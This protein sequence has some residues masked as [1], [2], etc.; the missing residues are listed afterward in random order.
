MNYTL[1]QLRI[2]ST[3][4]SLG[5]VTKTAEALNISQP[6][7]SIQLRNFQANFDINLLESSGRRV[8]L[9]EFGKQIAK[10][11]TDILGQVSAIDYTVMSHK[12][13]LAGQLRVAIVST[14]KYVMPYFLSPFIREHTGI[15]IKMDVTNK[16][17]VL[18]SL[19]EGL[20]DFGLVSVVP[21]GYD[22]EYIELMDNELYLIGNSEMEV[23]YMLSASDFFQRFPLLLRE[24]GS[25]TR[26]ASEQFMKESNLINA[27]KIEIVSNEAIKQAII[28]GIGCSVMP[29][30]GIRQELERGTL[31]VLPSPILPIVTK[32][33]LIWPEKRTLSPIAEAFRGYLFRHGEEV[34]QQFFK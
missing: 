17:S 18:H 4:A 30:I 32:W 22:F 12:G 2:F 3:M 31:R 6:A 25:A 33:Q 26:R 27:R 5:S 1:Q 29:R 11:A 13:F 24:E 23:A 8:I 16:A 9:T 21:K 19:A 7:V 10:L 34:A 14:G 15:A 20:T 28:A